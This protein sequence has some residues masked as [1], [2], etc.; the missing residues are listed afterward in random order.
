MAKIDLKKA[1]IK[2]LEE[3]HQALTKEAVK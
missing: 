2:K 3:T 1:E